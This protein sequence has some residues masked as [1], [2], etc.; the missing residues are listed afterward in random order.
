M[1]LLIYLLVVVFTYTNKK[2]T[3]HS[4]TKHKQLIFCAYAVFGVRAFF[5]SFVVGCICLGSTISIH[6]TLRLLY[7]ESPEAIKGRHN[8]RYSGKR[9]TRLLETSWLLRLVPV[10]GM[11]CACTAQMSSLKTIN[12][13]NITSFPYKNRFV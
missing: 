1:V 7:N 4:Q 2:D 13:W 5:L 11:H 6:V 12:V 3:I 9:N 10:C 8:S